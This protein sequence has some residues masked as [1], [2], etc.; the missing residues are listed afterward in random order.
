MD[1]NGCVRGMLCAVFIVLII[2]GTAQAFFVDSENTLEL[3][4]KA[5]TR[6]SFRTQDSEG[7]T[8]PQVPAGNLVQHRNLLLLEVSHDLKNLRDT[9]G[10]LYP[11]RALDLKV[12]YH[13]VGRFLYEGVYDYGP[14]AFQDVQDADKDNIDKFKQSYK[15][16]ECYADFSRGPLFLRIGKQNLAWGETDSFRLLDAINPLDNTYGGIFEDL[17]DRRIPLTMFRGSYN[18]GDIGPVGSL[19]LESFWVPGF[20]EAHVSPLTP[21]GT[22]YAAP[23]PPTPAPLQVRYIYPNKS[24]D[25]SRWG[26]RIMGV[27]GRSLNFSLAHYETFMDYPSVKFVVDPW[28]SLVSL[29]NMYEDITYEDVQITGASMNYWEKY[30][31]LVLRSEVA[32][33]WD[34]AVMI[35]DI[36]TPL[37]VIPLP[38]GAAPL[39]LPQ[40]GQIPRKNILRYMVGFD[41][42]L[43]IRPLN[44]TTTFFISFQYFGQYVL[45]YDK[46]MRQ[47]IALPPNSMDFAAQKEIETQMTA[48][49]ST[50][51]WNGRVSPQVALGYDVRG[52]WLIQ[53]SVNFIFE[54]FRFMIQWS[55][56]DGKITNF[57]AFRDRDQ[58]TFILSYLLN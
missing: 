31:D 37:F 21:Y 6:A 2:T 53:P 8:Y 11:F 25:S 33:F 51:Y 54:P 38:G 1:R 26:A 15:L 30:T 55:A 9:L 18:F 14:E 47:A 22:P 32:M 46:R 12:K 27:L 44:R 5:Q 19:T 42:N 20:W 34:E 41:K 56:I 48:L 57:G 39:T 50:S 28:T 4:G 10:L 7:F 36:N 29:P 52:A 35:P 3:S 23:L 16:W 17:D 43:W 24:I 40:N 45:D 49:M 58:I 13:L